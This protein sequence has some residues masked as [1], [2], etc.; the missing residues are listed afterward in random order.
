MYIHFY[1]ADTYLNKFALHSRYVHTTN[2]LVEPDFI[3]FDIEILV[4]NPNV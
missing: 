1:L 2:V 4:S 3:Y